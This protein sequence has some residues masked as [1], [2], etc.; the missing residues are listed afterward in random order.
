MA[1]FVTIITMKKVWKGPTVGSDGVISKG[2]MGVTVW[3]A[4][5]EASAAAHSDV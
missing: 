3:V 4:V 1:A 2:P 5:A